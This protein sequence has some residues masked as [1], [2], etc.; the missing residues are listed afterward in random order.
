M[1]GRLGVVFAGLA[2]A[3]AC[4]QAGVA[5]P[6]D[7]VAPSS[8]RQARSE[9]VWTKAV[10][11]EVTRYRYRYGPL[12]A[13]PGHNLILVGPAPIEKPAGDGYM[14]RVRPDLVDASG[15]AP[16][17][18]QVHMHHAVM[19]NL[20]RKDTTYPSLPQRFYGF[21]EEKTI[22][23]FPRPYGYPVASTDVWAINYMLHNETPEPKVVLIQYDVDWVPASSPTGRRMKPARPLWID[24][25]NGKAYPVFD[26]LRGE[27]RGGEMTYPDGVV[28]SPYGRGPKLNQWKVDRPG[29]LVAAAGHLHPGGLHVDLSAL[30]G[31]RSAHIFRSNAH[32]FDPNGPV[33]WDLAM[34][35]TPLS[36][37][38]GLRKGDVLRV[39]TTY[40]TR[41]ASWYES[42]GLVLAYIADGD[43]GPDPFKHRV[44][45]T[46]AITHGHLAAAN[47]H[48]GRPTSLPDPRKAP[49]GGTIAGGVAVADFTYLPGDL[50]SSSVLGRPPVV[51]RGS[52][53]HF[54][55][56]DSAGSIL[57]TVTACRAPCNGS[58]GVSYPLANGRIQFDSGQL[59]YGVPG[60]TPAAGRI[61]WRTAGDLP[62]GTYTYFCRVHPF[63]RGAFRVK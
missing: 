24:V 26:A 2:A 15:K 4:A 7:T 6:R 32:Y 17:I 42:M 40:E 41:R 60:Y 1:Q 20:S 50:S 59:G 33:S 25:Q 39:S 10:A 31:R 3:I 38:V 8:G 16:P 51:A 47:N 5:A 46:G 61:N 28:P 30:R 49:D 54:A 56:Y 27:G 12:L 19:L 55:N 29:T 63:M 43:T 52:S 57:H 13:A 18:E 53:L 44:Y 37:R 62:P 14:T 35:K 34:T 36:W 45:T 11:P 9:L 23:Q 22:G 48:G 58:T 21:A